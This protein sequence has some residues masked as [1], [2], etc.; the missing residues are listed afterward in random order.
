[1]C[2]ASSGPAAA[3]AAGASRR[4]SSLS[5]RVAI[6][7]SSSVQTAPP[8][9]SSRRARRLRRKRVGAEALGEALGRRHG[10]RVEPDL[11]REVELLRRQI[12]LLG[13]EHAGPLPVVGRPDVQHQAR[14]D[15]LAEVQLGGLEGDR[16]RAGRGQ[17]LELESRQ[18]RQ[19]RERLVRVRP[20]GGRPQ[21][22]EQRAQRADDRVRGV[23]VGR[24]ADRVLVA[25]EGVGRRPVGKRLEA[26]RG[27]RRGRLGGDARL[28]GEIGPSVAARAAADAER[29]RQR[30]APGRVG[31]RDAGQQLAAGGLDRDRVGRARE[32]PG[33]GVE[34][35]VDDEAQAA[36]VDLARDAP[37]DEPVRGQIAQPVR[38]LVLEAEHGLQRRG[39]WRRVGE[40]QPAA[41]RRDAADLPAGPH[42]RERRRQPR[43][44]REGAHAGVRARGVQLE[45]GCQPRAQRRAAALVEHVDVR[46]E[47]GEVD[48]LQRER[49]ARAAAAGAVEVR[50]GGAEPAGRDRAGRQCRRVH[51]RRQRGAV[52]L[53]RVEVDAELRAAARAVPADAGG[54]EPARRG[55]VAGQRAARDAGAAVERQVGG[56][57]DRAR[58]AVGVGA[59]GDVEGR[60]VRLVA[61]RAGRQREPLDQVA[62]AEARSRR[63]GP[64]AA[65]GSSA[66][67]AGCGR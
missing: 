1:M 3:G 47:R 21:L 26:V 63:S 5:R 23:P 52:H 54:A 56:I 6:G 28:G 51:G 40:G 50:A 10:N 13:H 38:S 49:R 59:A 64:G 29:I 12:D 58:A 17:V 41:Q 55:A 4:C 8:A 34:H 11:R 44:G 43:V 16:V 57:G 31:P 46:D 45:R 27:K 66:R 48:V 53:L 22:S 15:R 7:R 37:V 39:R 42:D 67:R 33:I 14:R 62:A 32:D 60:A 36:A 20:G 2:Q 24:A 9:S 19:R 30:D 65:P 25:L 61:A 18:R 35:V